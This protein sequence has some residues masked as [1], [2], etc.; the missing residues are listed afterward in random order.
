MM[1]GLLGFNWHSGLIVPL[2]PINLHRPVLSK[3]SLKIVNILR[4]MKAQRRILAHAHR[5]GWTDTDFT[6]L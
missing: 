5:Q 3:V 2:L 4:L 1:L 6:R